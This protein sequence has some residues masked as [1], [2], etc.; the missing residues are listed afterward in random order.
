[1]RAADGRVLS[2]VADQYART[3]RKLKVRLVDPE[4]RVSMV[5]T[6]VKVFAEQPRGSFE[7]FRALDD[8]LR[9]AMSTAVPSVTVTDAAK[10]RGLVF[11]VFAF[12]VSEEGGIRLKAAFAGEPDKLIRAVDCM[13]VSRI[14]CMHGPA[15]DA[16][17][18]AELLAPKPDAAAAA[19]YERLSGELLDGQ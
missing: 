8:A 11:K 14:L 19:Y 5:K 7:S 6:V 13:L 16:E 9:E 10:V 15:V 12:E 1:M 2:P 3:L 4:L 18:L 17:A